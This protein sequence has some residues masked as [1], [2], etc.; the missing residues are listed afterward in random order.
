MFKTS[1]F[2]KPHQ[3]TTVNMK[4]FKP[5]HLFQHVLSSRAAQ[6]FVPQTV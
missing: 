4:E 2:G 6:A 3:I 5:K 1:T